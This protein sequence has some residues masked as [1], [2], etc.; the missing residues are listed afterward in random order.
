[1]SN[2]SP[3]QNS[4]SPAK[5]IAM[6]VMFIFSFTMGIIG[7]AFLLITLVMGAMVNQAKTYD[8]VVAEVVS[9]RLEDNGDDYNTITT[10]RYTDKEG[11]VH[12]TDI[13]ADVSTSKVTIYCNPKNYNEV[14]YIDD[15]ERSEKIV[16]IFQVVSIVML[17]I[18]GLFLIIAI[19][20]AVL[21]A[22]RKK[23][24]A[25]QSATIY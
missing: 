10:V 4:N 2:V 22:K 23:S 14:I 5:I 25:A 20:L 6:V 9:S 12:T 3:A 7:L 24:A 17:S 13:T 1:M 15:L 21:V 19:V 11:E 8:P 16:P 18:G